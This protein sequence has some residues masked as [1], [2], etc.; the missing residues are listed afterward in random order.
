M[1][2]TYTY[3]LDAQIAL[4]FVSVVCSLTASTLLILRERKRIYQIRVAAILSQTRKHVQTLEEEMQA[5]LARDKWNNRMRCFGNEI[6][7]DKQRAKNIY[8]QLRAA[9][10]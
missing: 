9:G 3:Q 5:C 6:S 7:A 4:L 1:L 2:S 10:N 8:E